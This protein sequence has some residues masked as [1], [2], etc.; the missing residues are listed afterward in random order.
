MAMKSTLVFLMM[1]FGLDG[2]FLEYLQVNG[3]YLQSSVSFLLCL[4]HTRG[5]SVLPH[6]I[7]NYHNNQFRNNL[8]IEFRGTATA[9]TVFMALLPVELSMN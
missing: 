1:S 5:S 9:K 3:E 7:N 4:G 2:E 8:L 6:W